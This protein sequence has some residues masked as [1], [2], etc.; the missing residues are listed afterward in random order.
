MAFCPL[1]LRC[2]LAQGLRVFLLSVCLYP[3]WRESSRGDANSTVFETAA[4]CSV[5]RFPGG[6]ADF[7]YAKSQ[8]CTLKLV[9]SAC[10]QRSSHTGT[11]GGEAD[12]TAKEANTAAVAAAKEGIEEKE[13][14][15]DGSPVLS[16]SVTPTLVPLGS[17]FGDCRGAGNVVQIVSDNMVPVTYPPRSLPSSS[18][19]SSFVGVWSFCPI[20]RNLFTKAALVLF[21]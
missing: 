8:G 13:G 7:E 6:S 4:T 20:F 14:G 11:A 5:M 10:L 19:V 2:H 21:D 18:C 12:T 3:L 9:G 1:W 15:L 17:V 16:L